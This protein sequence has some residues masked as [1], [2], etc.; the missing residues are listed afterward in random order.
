MILVNRNIFLFIEGLG[1]DRIFSSL[2][3]YFS[4]K[5]FCIECT[6]RLYVSWSIL[7]MQNNSSQIDK[8]DNSFFAL[9]HDCRIFPWSSRV[10]SRLIRAFPWSICDSIVKISAFIF[11]IRLGFVTEFFSI[12]ISCAF[13]C[14]QVLLCNPSR[15]GMRPN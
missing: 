3:M 13:I 14:G 2:C 1:L 11:K 8:F 15:N 6:V 10:F 5:I 7:D 12:L 9:F 4:L